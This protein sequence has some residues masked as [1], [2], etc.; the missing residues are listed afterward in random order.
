VLLVWRDDRAVDGDIYAQNINLDG[1][2]GVAACDGDA[3]GDGDVDISD[4]GL[5]L[6]QFGQVGAGLDGDVDGDGD[7]DITDLGIMLANFGCG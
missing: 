7:V 2:L 3:D 5:L 4:L 6:S 1:S